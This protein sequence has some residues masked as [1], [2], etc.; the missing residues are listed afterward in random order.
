MLT[1]DRTA[2]AHIDP[3]GLPWGRIPVGVSRIVYK[4][5]DIAVRRQMMGMAATVPFGSSVSA[6]A[7]RMLVREV[8]SRWN[9]A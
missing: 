4:H 8:H 7:A 6:F 5:R 1:A 3:M 2:N 9:S